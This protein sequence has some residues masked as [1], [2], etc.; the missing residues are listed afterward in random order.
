M[1]S[2]GAFAACKSLKT[3]RFGEGLEV[4]GAD[5]YP[6][7]YKIRRGVF[8]KSALEHIEL[9]STLRRIEQNAFRECRSLRDIRLP[10]RLDPRF[11]EA[12]FGT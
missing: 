10:D 1:I 6:D 4:L 5:T 7:D 12:D 2:Q 11:P 3:V 8:E 9:P